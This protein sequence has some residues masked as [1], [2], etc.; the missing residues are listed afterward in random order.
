MV[1]TAR[2]VMARVFARTLSPRERED[3][4]AWAA[5]HRRLVREASAEPGRYD[6]E[7]TPYLKRPMRCFQSLEVRFLAL[8]CGSQ[9]GKTEL[10]ETIKQYVVDQDPGPTLVMAPNLE[11]ARDYNQDRFLPTVEASPR[12]RAHLRESPQDTK[13]LKIR[14][15]SCIFWFVG[16]NSPSGRRGRPCKN[17]LCDEIETYEKPKVG[18][19]GKVKSSWVEVFERVKTFPDHKVVCTST[20]EFEHEGIDALYREG[21]REKFYVPCPHCGAYQALTF[22]QLK[23]EGADGQVGSGGASAEQARKTAF[24]EC[25]G[26]KGRIHDWHKP[27]MLSRGVWKPE[28]RTIADVLEHGEGAVA[29]GVEAAHVSFQLSSLYSPFPGGGFGE[30]AA[31]FVRLHGVQTKEFVNGELGEA[32]SAVGDSLRE[33][34]LA[35]LCVPVGDLGGYRMGEVPEGCIGLVMSVDVQKDCAYVVVR[36]FGERGIDSWLIWWER[37]PR[38]EKGYLLEL[39][40]VPRLFKRRGGAGLRVGVEVYDSGHFTEQ[41]YSYV[42]RR[43]A[44]GGGVRAALAFA[45]KGSGT[46]TKPWDLRKIDVMPDG[47]TPIP[48]GVWLLLVNTDHWSDALHSRIKGRPD[49]GDDEEADV[50]AGQIPTFSL[51]DNRGGELDGYLRQM[52]AEGRKEVRTQRGMVSVWALKPGRKDNHAWDAERQL[53]AMAEARGVRSLRRTR[54]APQ[55]ASEER[56][57]SPLGTPPWA[58][59]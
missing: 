34:E 44:G 29:G 15:D 25:E 56:T 33:E 39:D 4:V 11:T 20:P 49:W 50:P 35:H 2:Q 12:M 45:G 7:R 32:W 36:G 58:R 54:P 30:I 51:P 22:E 43:R 52:T 31:K 57:E 40:R 24:Y 8:M 26:C 6:P 41:V 5:L 38:A 16:S 1:E 21:S 55:R 27:A 3:I 18:R 59:R 48:G 37:V 28:G 13:N 42:R 53:L 23:W 46:M 9:I 10:L 47:R 19:D 14:F 17:V